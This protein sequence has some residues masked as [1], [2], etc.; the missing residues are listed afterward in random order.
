[1]NGASALTFLREFLATLK[2]WVAKST[3]HAERPIGRF[4]VAN[5]F[6]FDETGLR[7]TDWLSTNPHRELLIN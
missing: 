3:K 7:K 1:M 5:M 4:F 6:F 2:N